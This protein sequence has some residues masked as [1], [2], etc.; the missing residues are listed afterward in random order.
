M[1]QEFLETTVEKFIF[2][3]KVGYLYDEEGVWV[4]T[5]EHSGIARL[6]L[7]DFRQQSS[8]DVAFVSLPAVGTSIEVGGEL[9]T[10][11]TIKVDL[12]VVSPLAGDIVAVNPTVED[13]PELINQDPYGEGWLVELKPASWPVEGLLDAAAYLAVMTQQAEAEAGS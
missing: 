1:T 7:T 12:E 13:A 8:G 2:R 3:V 9:V 5:D 4:A 11:E 10:I 6:G